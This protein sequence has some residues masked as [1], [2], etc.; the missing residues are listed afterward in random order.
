MSAILGRQDDRGSAP[1]HRRGTTRAGSLRAWP[2]TSSSQKEGEL[3][4]RRRRDCSNESALSGRLGR[5]GGRAPREDRERRDDDRECRADRDRD[6]TPLRVRESAEERK[7]GRSQ[8]CDEIREADE[9]T[10]LDRGRVGHELRGGRDVREVPAEPEEEERDRHPGDRLGEG[11]HHRR[12]GHDRESPEKRGPPSSAI[13]ERSDDEHERVHADDVQADDGEDVGLRVVVAD[14]DVPREVHHTGHDGEARDCGDHRRRHAGAAEDLPE[15]SG[16]NRRSRPAAR[17][18]RGLE[19]EGDRPRIGTDA[20]GDDQ[21]DERHGRSDEPG[22]DERVQLEVLAGEQ[23]TEDERAERRAEE[24]T[25][26]HVG[27]RSRLLLRRVHVRRGRPC[28]EDAAVHRADADEAEDHERRVVGETAES[29]E[30]A[31]D[32]SD[33]E[34]AGDDRNAAEAIHQSSG[35]KRRERAR[36]EEDRRPEAED[37]LDARDE[38]E[39]DRRDRDRKLDHARRA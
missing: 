8:P 38:D 19:L 13:H 10:A 37:R 15:R 23:R 24:R 32:R 33:H 34:A 26:E 25:E 3:V 1:R 9:P 30:H 27:D 22:D 18:V 39:R 21:P 4:V 14:D 36:R 6:D 29:R 16:R 35:R 12:H 5:R 17:P 2:C 11:E 31:A 20:E 28:Q 7:R